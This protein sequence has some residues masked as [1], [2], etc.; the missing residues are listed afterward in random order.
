M[1]AW[2]FVT[3][4]FALGAFS[5]LPFFAL[6]SPPEEPIELPSVKELAEGGVSTVRTRM[7]RRLLHCNALCVCVL[8]KLLTCGCIPQGPARALESPI[9][10]AL[11]LVA[12]LGLVGKAATAGD[13]AWVDF[14]HLFQESRFVHVT[15]LDFLTL[16]LAAPFWVWN[17]AAVRKYEGPLPAL[18]FAL[19]PLLGPVAWLSVR[20]R[21]PAE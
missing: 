18:L 15:T 14:G 11:L 4:S 6:W 7:W 12:T 3:G 19:T 21:A 17:D 1:P 20:P 9:T 10:A 13:A 5:L 2:P 8:R 16:S